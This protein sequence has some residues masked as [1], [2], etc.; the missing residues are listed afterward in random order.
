MAD[1]GYR[2]RM[3][4]TF[5]GDVHGWVDRLS[6]VVAQAEGPLVLMGDLIDRGPAVPD[7]LDLVHDLCDRGAATCLM[8]NHE[9]MLCRSLGRHGAAPDEDAFAAWVDG[10]GGDAVLAAY[11]VTS[12]LALRAALGSHLA[13]LDQLPWVLNGEADGSPWIAVHAG[14]TTHQPLALQMDDLRAGWDGPW[15]ISDDPRPL[16]LFSKQLV[17]TVPTDLAHG[18]RLVSGHTPLYQPYITTQR[19]CCDTSGGQRGRQLSGVVFPACRVVASQ[20]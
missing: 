4:V 5:I 10:W 15:S 8:G 1:H 12:A 2:P 11:G 7:V 19:I 18:T 3:P 16:P 6:E 13:W 9:W 17:R 20:L 14:L